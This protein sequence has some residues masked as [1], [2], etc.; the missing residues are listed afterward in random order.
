MFEPHPV[1][2]LVSPAIL[3]QDFLVVLVLVQGECQIVRQKVPVHVALQ[4][5]RA[6]AL[7]PSPMLTQTP[8]VVVVLP[9]PVPVPVPPMALAIL[10]CDQL[11]ANFDH[12]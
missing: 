2:L 1:Q 10:S 5:P 11:F 9:V 3:S 12:C 4:A 7:L 8:L 6:C